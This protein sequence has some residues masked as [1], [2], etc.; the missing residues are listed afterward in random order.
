MALLPADPGVLGIIWRMMICGAGF[1]F[2]QSPNLKAILSSAPPERSG[3]ASG[4]V[5]TSRLVGQST[6]AA[7]VAL[8]LGLSLRHGPA[9]ALGLAAVFSGIGCVVSF[10]RLALNRRPAGDMLRTAES[11]D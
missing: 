6:G 7:L 8:C 10:S 2:F 11:S 4:I 3:G 9:L 1:G 5:A